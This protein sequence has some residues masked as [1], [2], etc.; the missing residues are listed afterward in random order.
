MLESSNDD[1][2]PKK[3]ANRCVYNYGSIVADLQTLSC[4]KLV[5]LNTTTCIMV[6]SLG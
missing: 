3:D 4:L 6:S 2:S 5:P 1:E